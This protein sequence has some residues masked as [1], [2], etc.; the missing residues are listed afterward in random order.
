MPTDQRNDPYRGFNF[1]IEIDGRPLSSF[2]ADGVARHGI[3]NRRPFGHDVASS[4][5]HTVVPIEPA[6]DRAVEQPLPP[7]VPKRFTRAWRS[8]LRHLR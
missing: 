6:G 2:G 1:V 4:I 5:R 8:A 7:V 3:E